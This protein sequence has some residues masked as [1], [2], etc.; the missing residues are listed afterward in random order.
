MSILPADEVIRE[1]LQIREIEKQAADL[2]QK[3]R[4]KMLVD[5]K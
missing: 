5:I 1:N 4:Q 2:L 3:A